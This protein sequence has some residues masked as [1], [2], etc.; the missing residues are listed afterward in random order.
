MNAFHIP[1]GSRP[2]RDRVESGRKLAK[3]L[4]NYRGSDTLV[5]GIPRGGV[6]VAAEVARTIG[7]ELDVV[8][9][10]KLPAPNQPELAI[11]AVTAS[12][13]L[14]LEEEAI[15]DT[16]AHQDYLDN[17]IARQSSVARERETRF[18]GQT[19]P[20]RIA[21]RTVLIVDDGLA[22]GSTMRAAVNS[23][24]R[25]CPARLIVAVPVGSRQACEELGKDADAVICLLT[26]DPFW[27]VGL[28][29]HDFAAV[30]DDDVQHTL[31]EFG[32]SSGAPDPPVSD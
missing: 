24:A 18:R 26:P 2:Y 31:L 30:E 22:T 1:P 20:P 23:V 29:Y 10:R 28:Y 14:Y 25:L 21:D 4:A 7:A 5:L 8:V 16:G 19:P 3:A 6:P 11:G 32:S 17:E 12:G 27:A 15:V 9:A 13:G